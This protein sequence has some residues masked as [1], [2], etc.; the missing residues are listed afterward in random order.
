MAAAMTTANVENMNS[1]CSAAK[2]CRNSSAM[3]LN[4]NI[5]IFFGTPCGVSF[6]TYFRFF[7]F[8]YYYFYY[9]AKLFKSQYRM[10]EVVK[11]MLVFE[12]A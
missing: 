2:L 6:F 3:L 1:V 12:V 5:S 8:A 11:N 9:F 10:F 4:N 7:N